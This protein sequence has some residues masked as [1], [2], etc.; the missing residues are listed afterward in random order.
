MTKRVRIENADNSPYAVVVQVWQRH[1]GSP[2]APRQPD[3]L[4]REIRLDYP[5][6]ITPEDLCIWDT[7]YLVVKE[8]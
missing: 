1:P 6:A 4:V 7:R 8:A 5:T 3:I 2:D